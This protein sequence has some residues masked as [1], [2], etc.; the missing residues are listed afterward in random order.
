MNTIHLLRLASLTYFGIIAAALLM[1][2]VVGLRIHLKS[3]PEFIRALFWVYYMFL[4]L[5]LTAFGF[6]TFIFADDLASGTRSARAIC[7]FLALFW[8]ARLFTGIFIFDLRPYLTSAWRRIGLMAAN[9]AF[10]F[11]PIVYAWVALR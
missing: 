5:C 4:G 6:G 7:G 9:T 2:R 8:T 3:L 10:T 1:P 11:L